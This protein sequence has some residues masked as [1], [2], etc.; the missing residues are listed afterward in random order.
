MLSMT[1]T[2]A[3]FSCSSF[4]R[5]RGGRGATVDNILIREGKDKMTEVTPA[6]GGRAAGEMSSAAALTVVG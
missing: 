1:A 2:T 5:S 6:A 4:S 3:T